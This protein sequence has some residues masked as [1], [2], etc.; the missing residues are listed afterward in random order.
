MALAITDIDRFYITSSRGKNDVVNRQREAVLPHLPT[1]PAAFR[2][3]A[4][5]AVRAPRWRSLC[6]A[7]AAACSV[8]PANFS[9]VRL[10][11]KGGRGHHYDVEATIDESTPL[12]IEFKNGA[13]TLR[14]LPQFLSLPIKMSAPD[15]WLGVPAAD[16]YPAYFYRHHLQAAV[17]ALALPDALPLPDHDTYAQ[18]VNKHKS[19]HP[20]FVALRAHL[21]TPTG[22]AYKR[23]VDES[24]HAYLTRFSDG[25]ATVDPKAFLEKLEGQDAK[26]YLLWNK[27]TFSVAATELPTASTPIAVSFLA[28]N[29]KMLNRVVFAWAARQLIARL[30][31]RNDIGVLNPAWQISYR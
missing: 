22:P 21:K 16:T 27:G 5:D 30:R 24:I 20:F 29:K 17:D 12:P 15:P 13:T 14:A 4:V 25:T 18:Q 3:D 1:L 6:D 26:R 9:K 10:E 19:S 2:D 23:V 28:G 31:W 7:F 8:E 11:S